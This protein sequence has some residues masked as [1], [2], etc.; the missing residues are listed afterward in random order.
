MMLTLAIDTNVLNAAI[1]I[2]TALNPEENN[3]FSITEVHDK[4]I[5]NQITV[6][7]VT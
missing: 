3:I 2:H 7:T 6:Y 5:D 1:N 4:P